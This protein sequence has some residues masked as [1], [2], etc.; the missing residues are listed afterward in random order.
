MAV[1]MSSLR[2]QRSALMATL[3]TVENFPKCLS[4]DAM[5]PYSTVAF[6]P[7]KMIHTNEFF[8]TNSGTVLLD[9]NIDGATTSSTEGAWKSYFETAEILRERIKALDA[10]IGRSQREEEEVEQQLEPV[11]SGTER[12]P[13]VEQKKTPIA[14]MVVNE[15][16]TRMTN[17]EKTK[18]TTKLPQQTLSKPSPK[19]T[20]AATIKDVGGSSS[21][22]VFEIREFIDDA[23]NMTGHEVVDLAQQMKEIQHKVNAAMAQSEADKPPPPPTS[24]SSSSTPASAPRSLGMLACLYDSMTDP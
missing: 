17:D 14:K 15:S 24:S 7:G 22:G 21:G 6:S 10:Q 23:G 3:K 18:K 16:V 1:P 12:G 19:L 5:I 9:T 20:A 4:Y 11:D 2:E 13:H 8:V